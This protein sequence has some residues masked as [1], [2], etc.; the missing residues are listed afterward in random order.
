MKKRLYSITIT[1]TQADHGFATATSGRSLLFKPT[2][3]KEVYTKKVEDN[4]DQKLLSLN[5]QEEKTVEPNYYIEE[6]KKSNF[7]DLS[8]KSLTIAK[9][10][11]INE[12]K[13][14][15]LVLVAGGRERREREFREGPAQRS[16]Q[17]P[18][19][20]GPGSPAQVSACLVPLPGRYGAAGTGLPE[21][22]GQSGCA[23]RDAR[24]TAC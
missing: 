22:P 17:R 6:T 16:T 24:E 7:I 3:K 2:L 14:K 9:V 8:K 10:S 5:K 18:A 21:C 1:N 11:T 15:P 13:D 20:D 12:A 4:I 19:R 23:V